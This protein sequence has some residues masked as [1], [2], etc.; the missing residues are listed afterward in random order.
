MKTKLGCFIIALVLLASLAQTMRAAVVFTVTPSAIS[1]TYNGPITLQVTGLT[2]KDT[3]VVQ[4]FLD[5]NTNGIVDAVDVLWQQFS[6]TEGTNLVIGGVTNI[7]VPG[8]TDGT[9]NGQITAKLN[10]QADFSQT[11]VGK[12]LFKLSSPAGHFTPM[13]NSFTVTNFPFAQKFTG[14]VVSNGVAV[15]DAVVIL[16]QG[17]GGP[18]EVTA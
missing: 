1:N 2:S 12:Y 17:S 4:K 15:P 11:I 9:A 6:L 18:L 7:N 14:T 10:F 16:L 13:T 8:D 5:A 3:V